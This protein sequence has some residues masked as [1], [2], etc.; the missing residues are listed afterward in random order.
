MACTKSK[1]AKATGLTAEQQKILA[2]LAATAEPC[3]CKDI[4]EQSGMSSQAVNCKLKSLKTQGYVD[5]P[6]RCKYSITPAGK[7]ALAAG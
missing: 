4:A 2:S 1:C 6:I 3:G 7:N 5:S